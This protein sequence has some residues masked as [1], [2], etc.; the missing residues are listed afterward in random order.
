[1]TEELAPFRVREIVLVL[2]AL[3]PWRYRAASRRVGVRADMVRISTTSSS[4]IS[5][6]V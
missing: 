3:G 4:L 2:H 5:M 6:W 1:L